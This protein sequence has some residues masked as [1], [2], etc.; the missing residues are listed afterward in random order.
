MKGRS[1]TTN[2]HANHGASATSDNPAIR[3]YQEANDK[4]HGDMT[5]EF[6]GDADTDFMRGMIPHHQGAIDM[7]KVVLAHGSDAEVRQLAEDVIRAQEGEIA[8]MKKWL[9]DRG[10]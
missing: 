3:A 2:K 8:K 4:M 6:T 1:M 10:L 9:S 7:A 5:I